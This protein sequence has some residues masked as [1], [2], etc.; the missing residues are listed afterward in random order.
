MKDKDT[1]LESINNEL[2][3]AFNSEDESWIGGN[4]ITNTAVATY[5]P[6]GPDAMLDLDFWD[7]EPQ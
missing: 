7:V 5:G 4:K 2:F 3:G 6:G 1:E